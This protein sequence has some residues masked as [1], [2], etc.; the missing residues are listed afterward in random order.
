MLKMLLD[1]VCRFS[2]NANARGGWAYSSQKS[3]DHVCSG[4]GFVSNFVVFLCMH[5]SV[6]TMSS[7]RLVEKG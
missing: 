1:L 7:S 3:Q 4:G 2:R 6:N 5:A